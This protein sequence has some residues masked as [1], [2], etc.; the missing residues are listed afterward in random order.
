MIVLSSPYDHPAWNLAAEQ[1]LLQGG[2]ECLLLYVNGPS[3][4][5]GRN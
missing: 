4:V 3:V 5:L 2:D 1:Y